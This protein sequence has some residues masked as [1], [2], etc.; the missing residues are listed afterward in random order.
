MGRWGWCLAL[1]LAIAPL[2]AYAADQAQE[3]PANPMDW[4]FSVKPKKT[5][6]ELELEKWVPL[7]A[8]ETGVYFFNKD[9]IGPVKD[10]GSVQEVTV[11]SIFR[12]EKV[13]K[14]L[15]E[16]YASL[17]EED[18][19]VFFC[20]MVL[21]MNTGSY[22]YRIMDTKIFTEEG[23]LIKEQNT[24]ESV[25]KEAV[26]NTFAYIMLQGLQSLNRR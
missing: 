7:M 2:P 13:R 20:D 12:D 17:L 26:P 11:R 16:R 18:E 23:R 24:N 25:W 14:M 4:E 9:S 19:H 21:Q 15:D 22:T 10:A 1:F 5:A 8:N 6:Q 3:V